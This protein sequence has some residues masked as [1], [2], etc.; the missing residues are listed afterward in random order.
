MSLL[1]NVDPGRIVCSLYRRPGALMAAAMNTTPEAATVR[2]K[3]DYEELG[4]PGLARR[5][6]VDAYVMSTF[7]Y[8]D[9]RHSHPR[10]KRTFEG[11]R[12]EIA[13]HDGCAPVTVQPFNF[14]L[15]MVGK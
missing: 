7:E 5:P 8:V 2:V 10:P 6:W 1:D 15:L 13:Q 4:A 3:L 14:R 12:V 11:K 9:Y